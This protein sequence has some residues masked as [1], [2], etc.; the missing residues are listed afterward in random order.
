MK[1]ALKNKLENMLPD[2][3]SGELDGLEREY[4]EREVVNFPHLEEL[5]QDS[6]AIYS[7]IERIDYDSIF[8]VKSC[9]LATKAKL[10][11]IQ[12][13]SNHFWKYALAPMVVILAVSIYYFADINIQSP[14]NQKAIATEFGITDEFL[15]DYSE[16]YIDV[17]GEA[18]DEIIN[19]KEDIDENTDMTESF[20]DDIFEKLSESTDL[21]YI[22]SGFNLFRINTEKNEN[23]NLDNIIEE[24]L[25]N[26]I[27]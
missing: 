25:N 16:A 26:E 18:A 21:M 19:Y 8:E 13:K 23:N 12:H 6:K 15:D 22:Y 4:F 27:I 14:K 10:K 24:M 20:F 5:V 7:R 9:N 11:A 17:R 1:R 2:Y 3:I